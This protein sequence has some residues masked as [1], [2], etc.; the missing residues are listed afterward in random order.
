MRNYNQNPVYN[1][2]AVYKD[3]GLKPDVLRAW[4]RR[5]GLPQPQ[6][7]AGGHRLYSRYDIELIKWLLARQ[8]QGMRISQAVDLW[9]EQTKSGSDPL[10]G[11][12]EEVSTP[13]IQPQQSNLDGLR[14]IWLKACYE[15]DE[16]AA[17]EVL[18]QAFSIYSVETVCTGLLQ[19][20]LRDV[21][22]A[23]FNGTASVQQEHFASSLA[24][25]R[26]ETLITGSPMPTRPQ[27]ILVGCPPGEWHT[28]SPL[29]LTLL[30]RRGGW[31]VVYLGANVPLAQFSH[32]VDLVRPDLVV[33]TAQQL[34]TVVSLKEMMTTL[35]KMPVQTAYGGQIFNRIS[36]LRDQIPAVFLG[37]LIP[38]AISIIESLVSAPQPISGNSVHR[39]AL[40][41][42]SAAFKPWEASSF[43]PALWV[44]FREQRRHIELV[45]YELLK[46]DNTLFE[47]VDTSTAYF[48]DEMVAA[49]ELG[50][51][52][53]LTPDI[54]WIRLLIK[55]NH[56]PPAT[57]DHFLRTYAQAV[58]QILD[59]EGGPIVAWLHQIVS[60]TNQG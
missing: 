51:L 54:E 19:M 1:L 53:F 39:Q 50:D 58:H 27:T 60:N 26:L 3:T 36:A 47:A 17:E 37:E 12:K 7:T 33:L 42:K 43:S 48:G 55:N 57:V 30:L 24:M 11:V 40:L 5:Y 6:R 22:E 32:A 28:F 44:R 16:R 25:R 2:K 35:K 46:V 10:A 52:D 45:L 31:N 59:E 49:L 23:W 18:N 15:F 41:S 13:N 9:K 34:T 14:Q 29:L 38:S 20:G 56:L 8:E 21:G 4:E